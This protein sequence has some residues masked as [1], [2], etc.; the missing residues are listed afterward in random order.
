MLVIFF[1]IVFLAELIIA[2]WI[3]GKINNARKLVAEYNQQVTNLQP[4]IKS[5][6]IS[7]RENITKTLNSLN[8][9]VRFLAEKKCQCTGLIER[10]ILSTFLAFITKLPY[11]QI[12]SILEILLTLKKFLKK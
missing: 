4:V 12:L 6:I 3:I 2:S 5:G 10:N 9:F 8:S 1:T 11:K 7:T